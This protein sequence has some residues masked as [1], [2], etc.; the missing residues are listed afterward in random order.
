QRYYT[1]VEDL[2]AGHVTGKLEKDTVVTLSDT[3]VTRSS[4][5][6]QFTE[7]TITSETKNAAGNT[8]AAGTKVWTVSDQGSLKV[9]ASAPVPSWWTKC[10]P[11]YTNQSES[12][13]NCTSRTNWAYYLSSD[14]VLQYKNAGSLVADFPLSYEPDNT[15]QQVIRPGKNAGDAERTFSLV[16]L[17]RDKDKLKKDDRVWVVSDGDS[18]TPVAP[19]ASSSE[20]VFNGVYVPPTPVPV[21][22]GDS[23]GHLGFY[24]LPEENGKRSRYQVH[25]ECLSMDDMEKFI[26]NPGRVGEDTPVYLTWQADAPLFEKGEQGMVAG[27]RKT[28]ISGIVTLAKVPGVDA[29][30]TALSDNKDAAYFQIRQEGGWLPTASVQKVSQYALGELGFATLDKAPA[31]FDLIDGI[32]QPNNVVKGILEQLYKAAQEETRT[33]HALN[34]YNYKRLLELIDRNQ[35]GYYSEQEYLQAI[36]NV[37][38]RDHLYRVIAKHASEWYYGKDAPLWKTYLDTLTTDAPLWKMY[39]ETFLDKMTWMKAVSE[40]GVPLGPA[41]WHMHPIVFMDSLS[42]KKTHQIIFPLKV[43]PKNDK[44]G[45]WKDYYWAAALSDSNASQSIFGRNRDSGRRKHAARDLYTEPR[46]EIVAICAGV[47]KSISTYYYGTWQITIEHKTNDGREFFIRY[48]E[49]EHNS[50]IVNVGDRVLLGS[51][52][53]RTGLLINPRTQRHPN[54]IPGQIVYMLHLEYYTNMSE[55]VPPNNTGGTVTPYDRR[56][57][58]QDP[59][60]ILREGYKNTF[61]QDDANERIDINQLNISEQGKQFIKEWEG[62]RTEAYNDS[63]GYCTIGYGHLIARDRCESITLPDEFSHGITQE[64]ANELFEER[65]P[66]YVDGVKSSVSV[67]LYQYEFDALVCLLFNIGSSGLRLKAPMLRNKLNQEDYEGAAQEFLDIT[68]GGESGLVARRI[69]ENN[70][71]LNNIYDASH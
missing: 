46:A 10:S 47:V 11:A 68:N 70:L 9:A 62:L 41:P 26:T 3:I 45:I 39:L 55:G 12:V 60:D 65:L 49:V 67:K 40:K 52:I 30:G 71:F 2:Q 51:V 27:S 13:V 1:S 16:T 59:L 14:D 37:S 22:A 24:Q 21:S 4:D 8:L 25:I 61:E 23:L 43:K 44:R 42:Q 5:K 7:V 17:G 48:G 31:S 63:E 50:I 64:R 56:S 33:T 32:N 54:I 69:S 19:A 53:A 66:S 29:A 57:D 58:L 28:K 20:P 34:K 6:R 35:D 36:H 38:Y 18:L 15:A